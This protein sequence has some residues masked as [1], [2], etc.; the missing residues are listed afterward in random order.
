MPRQAKQFIPWS[1]RQLLPTE[2][3][4][5][6]LA[7]SLLQDYPRLLAIPIPTTTRVQ[8][9]YNHPE[10]II[11]I[12]PT[13]HALLYGRQLKSA[14]LH[15]GRTD[16]WHRGLQLA[17]DINFTDPG[18]AAWWEQELA[19]CARSVGVEL[20]VRVQIVNLTKGE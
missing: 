3:D 13:I 10:R 17:A 15:P 2:E 20:Q 19:A 11:P 18:C 5:R 12:T 8:W 9:Y 16:T 6:V 1:Q 4:L 7:A 14:P